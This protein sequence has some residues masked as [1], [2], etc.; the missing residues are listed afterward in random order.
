M[1]LTGDIAPGCAARASRW[2]S[3]R[4][5]SVPRGRRRRARRRGTRAVRHPRAGHLPQPA[6]RARHPRHHRR[7]RR[8]RGHRRH[9]PVAS[10]GGAA[11]SPRRSRGA[12]GAGRVRPGLRPGLAPASTPT[13]SCSSASASGTA[14]PEH[15][16]ARRSN[17][18]DTPRIYT[19]L[20]G[21][22]YGRS[23]EQVVPVASPCWSPCRWR[24]WCAASSTCSRSTRTPPAGR[25]PARAGPAPGPGAAVLTAMA[26][27]AVGWSASSVSSRRTSP[28][29]RR[30]PQRPRGAVAV[31]V[32][33]VLLVR[34]HRR[35][36]RDRAGAGA[37]R[38]RRRAHR[39][40]VLRLPAGSL[41]RLTPPEPAP[42]PL[43]RSPHF[44]SACPC[45]RED[46]GPGALLED[47]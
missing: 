8:R 32:G 7:R 13:G 22:T 2:C 40:A 39:R 27:A 29:A 46:S 18:W 31:L 26:V 41:P 5:T 47:A 36:H 37:R 42:R 10:A 11:A 19:W 21:S 17:P 25:R 3:S 14:A 6:R 1:A 15:L 34:R 4:S 30:R 44:L 43:G 23:W 35:P 20:S 45:V 16:P 9:R 24:S 38:A 33:A 12:V 28:R